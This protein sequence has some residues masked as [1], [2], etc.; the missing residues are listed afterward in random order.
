MVR[1]SEEREAQYARDWNLG[2]LIMIGYHEPKKY[3]KLK[4]ISPNKKETKGESFDDRIKEH[5]KK[6]GIKL[7]G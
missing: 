4:A 5:A 1:Y 2:Q 6:L 7:P 3:P